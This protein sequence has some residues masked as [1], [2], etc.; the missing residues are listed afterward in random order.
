MYVEFEEL[1]ITE[2]R[3][4]ISRLGLPAREK[5]I[6][7]LRYAEGFSYDRIAAEMCLSKSS[8]GSMLSKARKHAVSLAKALY[9]ICDDRAQRLIAIIGWDSLEWPTLESRRKENDPA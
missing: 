2:Q 7:E 6:L 1:P 4:L 5:R 3:Y 8:I 9:P